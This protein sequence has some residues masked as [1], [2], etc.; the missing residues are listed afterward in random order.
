LKS[1]GIESIFELAVSVPLDLLEYCTEQVAVDLVMRVRKALTNS[2][3]FGKDFSTAEDLLDQRRKIK[4]Q[5]YRNDLDFLGYGHNWR[6]NS[7][8]GELSMGPPK[9]PSDGRNYVTRNPMGP[10]C[11]ICCM[12]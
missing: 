8:H 7:S 10:A 9:I 11:W 6:G 1:A 5:R 3:T 2:G 4:G 12:Y